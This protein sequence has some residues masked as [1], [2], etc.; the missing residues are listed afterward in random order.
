MLQQIDPNWVP[1][2]RW[3]EI[4]DAALRRLAA[5][6]AV[7]RI[8]ALEIGVEPKSVK[9]R[10]KRIGITLAS[11]RARGAPKARRSNAKPID[12]APLPI[13]DLTLVRTGPQSY[14]ISGA[15]KGSTPRHWETR[16]LYECCWPVEGEGADL[17]SCC[18][19]VLFA[20]SEDHKP[21]C[22]AHYGRS[23]QRKRTDA[24]I[25]ADH[26]RRL[27]FARKKHENR[28]FNPSFGRGT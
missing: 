16:K 21:Y 5:L 20:D 8:I 1:G 22:K 13:P 3:T 19:P 11:G 14:K 18:L 2:Q 7:P 26:A 4:M 25:S 23:I 27:A 12:R 10:A 28:A 24:E 17:L 6:N 15:V 9:K